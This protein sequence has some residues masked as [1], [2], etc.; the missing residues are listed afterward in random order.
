MRVR[1]LDGREKPVLSRRPEN[2]ET[3]NAVVQQSAPSE[4]A[5]LKHLTVPYPTSYIQLADIHHSP[6]GFPEVV[7]TVSIVAYPHAELIKMRRL[8][9]R[10]TSALQA[11]TRT[12]SLQE[13]PGKI[14]ACF[15]HS[16]GPPH[17]LTLLVTSPI[18]LCMRHYGL[19]FS[20]RTRYCSCPL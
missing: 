13:G 4:A 18:R 11:S 2:D 20:S 1:S 5:S 8:T 15:R 14:G 12:F 9:K 7:P 17:Y 3:W 6:S 10:R 16:S 19:Y